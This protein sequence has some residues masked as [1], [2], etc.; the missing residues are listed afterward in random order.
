MTS[1]NTGNEWYGILGNCTVRL[2]WAGDN[3]YNRVYVGFVN[4]VLHYHIVSIVLT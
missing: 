1:I 3:Q 4:V 2:Y